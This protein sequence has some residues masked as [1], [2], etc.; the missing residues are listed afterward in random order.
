ML[1]QLK[2]RCKVTFY[3]ADT[4]LRMFYGR[5]WRWLVAHRKDAVRPSLARISY[6]LGY[7]IAFAR[8]CAWII[9]R[10]RGLTASLD[11]PFPVLLMVWAEEA[12]VPRH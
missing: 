10:A 2:M 6:G 7:L 9:E 8:D 5:K 4:R 12:P 3:Y 1:G 11:D